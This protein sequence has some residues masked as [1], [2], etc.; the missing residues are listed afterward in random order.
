MP[1]LGPGDIFPKSYDENRSGYC[2]SESGE[3]TRSG[4]DIGRRACTP[5]TS[6]TLAQTG[7]GFRHNFLKSCPQDLKMV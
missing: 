1:F 4:F 5:P 7:S 2:D 6:V 3:K